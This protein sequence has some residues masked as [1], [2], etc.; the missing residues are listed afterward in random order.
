MLRPDARLATSIATEQSEQSRP[1]TAMSAFDESRVNR[2]AAGNSTGGQFANKARPANDS[3]GLGEPENPYSWL[4]EGVKKMLDETPSETLQEYIDQRQEREYLNYAEREEEKRHQ[5]YLEQEREERYNRRA[6]DDLEDL[7]WKPDYPGYEGEKYLLVAAQ[8]NSGEVGNY[9]RHRAGYGYGKHITRSKIIAMEESGELAPW[10]RETFDKFN[11]WVGRNQKKLK[12]NSGGTNLMC[13]IDTND[14]LLRAEQDRAATYP[15]YV[16][17]RDKRLTHY[18]T[19]AAATVEA[20]ED[21]GDA[22]GMR[23][24]RQRIRDDYEKI[25]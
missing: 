8:N 17:G 2:Q 13:V 23:V 22:V 12:R 4:V 24:F 3:V 14:F 19:V 15:E 21:K 20:V 9:R 18:L 7:G 6:E 16:S 25:Y 11:D 1:T 10:A 5:A